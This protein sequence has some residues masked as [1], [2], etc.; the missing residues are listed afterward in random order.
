MLDCEWEKTLNNAPFDLLFGKDD[1][2]QR[3]YENFARKLEFLTSGGQR[4]S[5][6]NVSEAFRKIDGLET[7]LYMSTQQ[8]NS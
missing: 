8:D 1:P 4:H 5:S 7:T 3:F 6:N 2:S